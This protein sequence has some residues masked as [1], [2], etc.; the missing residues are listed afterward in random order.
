[1][2]ATEKLTAEMLAEADLVLITTDHSCFDYDLIAAKAKVVF[3]TRNA[4]KDK[5][6][7]I[8]YKL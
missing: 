4:L 5:R 7:L 1:M 2:K 3:D 6:P 8:Y